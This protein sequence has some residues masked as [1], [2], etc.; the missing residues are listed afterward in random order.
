M[1]MTQQSP[2]T[3]R[4]VPNHREPIPL[5]F[6]IALIATPFVPLAALIV[7]ILMVRREGTQVFG[8]ILQRAS[9]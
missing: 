7:G 2:P 9:R 1:A 8:R 4:P 5:E 3:A 6:V